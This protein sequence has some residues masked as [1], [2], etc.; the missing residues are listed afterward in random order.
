VAPDGLREGVTRGGSYTVVWV[1]VPDPIPLN[2]PFELDVVITHAE[3]GTPVIDAT[4]MIE[5][6]MP[7]HGHGMNRHPRVIGRV[8]G[9]YRV[10]GMLFHMSGFWQIDID[11]IRQHVAEGVRFDVDL[12]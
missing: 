1:P 2:E 7:A 3:D 11:V 8:E 5:A 4:L 6:T 10:A 9:R 12:P